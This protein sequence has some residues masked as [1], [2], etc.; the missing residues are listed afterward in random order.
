MANV[1]CACRFGGFL[2]GAVAIT[3]KY[4]RCGVIP[5]RSFIKIMYKKSIPRNAQ[6]ADKVLAITGGD[7]L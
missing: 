5:F 3:T 4:G 6:I 7:F 2:L 1:A